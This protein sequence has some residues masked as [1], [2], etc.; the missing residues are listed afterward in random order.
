MALEILKDSILQE[1]EKGFLPLSSNSPPTS[2]ADLA[3]AY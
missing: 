2:S 1:G 3:F